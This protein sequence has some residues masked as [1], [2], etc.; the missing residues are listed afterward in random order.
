MK[1]NDY[2]KPAMMV[3]KLQH[4]NH[5]LEMSGDPQP[6]KNVSKQGYQSEEW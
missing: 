1:K 2:M 6:V 4:Q 5:L 3:V